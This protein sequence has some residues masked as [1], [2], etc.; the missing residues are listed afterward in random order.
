MCGHVSQATC[1]AHAKHLTICP[2][3]AEDDR[4]KIRWLETDTARPDG[5]AARASDYVAIEN[6]KADDGYMENYL[7]LDGDTPIGSFGISLGQ[8]DLV[9]I[10]NLLLAKEHRG[11]GLGSAAI[12]F[13]AQ[14]ANRL[15]RWWIGAFALSPGPALN[16]YESHGMT[17]I[18]IQT[19]M[20][21]PLAMLSNES[22]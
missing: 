17:A 1:A 7:I 19:E 18:G 10:K 22:S 14:Q 3:E 6:A 9:R 13:A 4:L 15:S 12:R 16:L 20:I 8:P 11:R 21:A 5:K 2:L